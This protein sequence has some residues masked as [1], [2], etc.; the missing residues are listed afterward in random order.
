MKCNQI[1]PVF[2]LVYPIPFPKIKTISLSV[3]CK[4]FL[5][6]NLFPFL[7]YIYIYIYIYIYVCV[8]V[9]VCVCPNIGMKTHY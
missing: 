6:Y 9:C 1:H 5:R 7:Q 2:V 4:Y 3:Y 8:C